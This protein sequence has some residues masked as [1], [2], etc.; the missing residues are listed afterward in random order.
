LSSQSIAAVCLS[1]L[2][3]AAHAVDADFVRA[4][5]DR[6]VQ[7]LVAQHDV[8]GMA[9]AVTVDGHAYFFNYGVASKEGHVPVTANTLFELGSV[10]KTLTATLGCHA[11][12]LGKLSFDDHPGK[13][14]P[15]LKGS[16]ID[17]A[18]VLELGTYTAGG[19]PLQFPDEVETD[20]QTVA[21]FRNWH[22]DAAPGTQ[23]R[24][25]NPSIGLFGHVTAR[26]LG[27]GFADAVEGRLFPAL[28]LK[29]SYIRV[30]QDAMGD[31]AWG[32]DKA[33]QPVRVSP[34]PFDAEAYGVK[35]SAADMI[36][37]VQANI[38]AGGLAEP[39][40]RAVACTHMGRF[41]IGDMV[42]GLGWEQYRAPVSLP[43][44]QAGNSTK[45]SGEPNPATRLEPPQA[46]PR[47]TVFN[48][49]GATRGFGTYV[50]FAP[51]ERI[52]IVMLANKNYP[53]AARV[54]A[55]YS[56]LKQL[57]PGV[58]Q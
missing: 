22:P 57:A 44:L 25:S 13:Y 26:A 5:V 7:P 14:M 12:D 6:A 42:Q 21:Y 18:T 51:D 54:Q 24:Y 52:G 16:A 2:P 11:Q 58:V 40:Q 20:A 32:Y 30:P 34:G 43:I 33:N 35:S 53:I 48:K 27:T 8:P 41:R 17:R 15:Q 23:R 28:G 46:P 47:G 3:F 55:A 38:D 45:M 39:V 4:A 50:L 9:V 49:T 1:L 31:Y 19:L 29:H 36:R 56:I 10:S 37:F